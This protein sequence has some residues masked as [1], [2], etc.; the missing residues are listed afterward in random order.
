MAFAHDKELRSGYLQDKAVTAKDLMIQP[1]PPR[2]LREGD[3]LEFTVKVSNQSAV[4]Q[5]G[6]VRLTFN[7]ART[8]KSADDA[9]GLKNLDQGFDIPAKESKSFSWKI[10]VPDDM[11]FLTYKAVGSTGKIS[12]GEQGYLPVLSRR[13]MVTESLP[14]PIRGKGEKKFEFEKLLRIR[15]VE[16]PPEQNLHRPDGLEPV[17]VCGDGVAL[18]HGVPARVLRADLQPPLREHARRA[19]RELGSEDPPHLRPVARHRR[20]RQP[21]GEKP[22][23]QGVS[24]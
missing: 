1:N 9:L 19:H 15:E 23:S 10:K 12:D 14:L 6:T 24:C 7:D 17:L 13:I 21:D 4:A 20:P 2:F 18:P 3:L 16:N 22:G 8:D 11:G 5:A